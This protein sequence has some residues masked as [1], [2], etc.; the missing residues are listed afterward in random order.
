MALEK[1][2][3]LELGAHHNQVEFVSTITGGPSRLV[4]AVHML[5]L[6]FLGDLQWNNNG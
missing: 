2:H 6:Q 1:G 4:Y 5:S 3:P